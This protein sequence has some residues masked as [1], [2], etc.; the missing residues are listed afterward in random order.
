MNMVTAGI[1]IDTNHDM[2][3][4]FLPFYHIYGEFLVVL[5]SQVFELIKILQVLP[6]CFIGL[7]HSVSQWLS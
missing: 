2:M 6:N 1:Q 7:S 3:L 5:F 4:G